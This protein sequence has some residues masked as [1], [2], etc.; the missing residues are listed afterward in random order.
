[1]E[2]RI[3]GEFLPRQPAV[4]VLRPQPLHRALL[5]RADTTGA[6]LRALVAA[7]LVVMV[8]MTAAALM[9]DEPEQARP[10]MP[11]ASAPIAHP[12]PGHG[13]ALVLPAGRTDRR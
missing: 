2:H 10:A 4:P 9:G 7:G 5:T 3:L 1:M 12:A 8:L 11:P 6:L 13:D